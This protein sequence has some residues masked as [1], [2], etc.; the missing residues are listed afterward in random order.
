MLAL[1]LML[2]LLP[3]FAS[4][5]GPQPGLENFT[6]RNTYA[7]GQ[8]TDVAEN[9]W[10]YENVK[11]VYELGLMQGKLNQCFDPDGSITIAEAITLAVR[12]HAIYYGS[13]FRPDNSEQPW[14]RPYVEYAVTNGIIQ[15]NYSDCDQA[16]TRLQL[17]TI[18]SG[19]LPESELEQINQVADNAIPDVKTAD[20]GAAEVYLFY[21]AGI[22]T[23]NDDKGTFTP[24]SSIRRSET[25]AAVTRMVKP[26]LRKSVTLEGP[27]PEIQKALELGIVPEQLQGDYEKQI[28]YAEFAAMLA[29]VIQAADPNALSQWNS[30]AAKALK[31]NSGMERDDGILA[32]YEAACVL[33]MGD[34]GTAYWNQTNACY[35]L[36]NFSSGY[37][38]RRDIFPNCRETA[39]FEFNQG[40]APEADYIDCAILYVMGLSS[41]QNTNPYFSQCSTSLKYSDALTADEAIKAAYRLYISYQTKWEGSFDNSDCATDWSDPTLAQAKLA[42]DAILNSPTAIKKSS[43]LVLGETYTGTAYYVSNSGKDSND[44]KSPSS[45]WATLEKVKTARLAYGDAVFFERG[46]TWCGSLQMQTGVTYSAYGTGDKPVLTGSPADAAQNEKWSYYGPTDD[47]GK[48]WKYKD[49]VPDCGVILLNGE[50]VARKAY[51]VWDG[52][53]YSNNSGEKFTIEKGLFAD[54]MYFSELDLSGQSLPVAVWQLGLI[55]QLYLRCDAGNPGDVFD[56]IELALVSN[57]TTTAPEGWNAIDNLNFRCYSG[58]GMDCC[59]HDHLI[60]QNC[61]TSWCGGAV[62]EYA[63]GRWRPVITVSG[64]GALMFGSDVT[65]RN[66]YIHDCESK[67]LSV[68]INGGGGDGHASLERVNV[69][70]EG[71]V[72]ERCG[73]AVHLWTGMFAPNEVWKF[74]DVVFRG[75]YFVNSAYGWRIHNEMWIGSGIGTVG[76][77]DEAVSVDNLYSTGEVKLENNLFYRAAGCLVSFVG[78]NYSAGSKVPTMS[79]NTYVQDKD[80]LVFSKNDEACSIK[81]LGTLASDDTALLDRCLREYIGD[82]TGKIIVLN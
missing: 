3:G 8:F 61:E 14:Y 7:A 31:T 67:G 20:T 28:S 75:N 49:K 38:P 64:G 9:S 51:P 53:Q 42:L 82:K 4:A 29:N 79:G 46:G 52:K 36:N 10:Y 81:Q 72:V 77:H 26:E 37:S 56:T 60:Y 11:S 59:S 63:P 27:D 33:G 39:P 62:K 25:A 71:N 41:A 48:I 58:S 12:L 47:G 54:L 65:F 80:R 13:P 43:T 44:G 2:G 6:E 76:V 69:L 40:E 19:A 18:L 32:L 78:E 35:T 22:L 24:N 21:R 15:D 1:C 57:A 68:V 16:A 17:V 30:V 70:A 23:G 74:E 55:G 66:N 5:E 50:V 34:R 73:S 45:A